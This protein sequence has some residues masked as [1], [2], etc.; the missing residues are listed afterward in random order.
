MSPGPPL[1]TGLSTRSRLLLEGP[2]PVGLRISPG[3]Q[4]LM[5]GGLKMST[6]APPDPLIEVGLSMSPLQDPVGLR[7]SLHLCCW[8]RK[9]P[10]GET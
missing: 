8:G 6:T 1:A 3:M 10:P 2:L 4:P 5:T 7:I 9:S